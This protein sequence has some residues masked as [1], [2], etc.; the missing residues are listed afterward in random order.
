MAKR[1]VPVKYTSRDFETIR[2]DLVDYA[3]RYYPDTFK[4][5]SEASFGS[6]MLD[7]VAYVGDMLSFYVDYQANESFLDTATER[8]NIIR[9]AKEHGYKYQ[10]AATTVGE[11]TFYALIPANTSGLGPDSRYFPILK[12]NSTV[13]GGGAS[14]YILTEDVRFDNPG[15]Y[16]VASRTDPTTG[17]PTQYAVKAKGSVVSGIFGTEDIT[18][19][20]FEKFR[21][22][23]I[24]VS[25]VAEILQVLDADGNEYFEVEYL[26]HDVVYKSVP[27]RDANTRDN[28][29]SLLRPFSVPRRFTVERGNGATFLQFG[30]GSDSEISSPTVA[31]PST[32]IL[33]RHAKSYVTDSAFDPSDLMGTDKLGVGP[34]NTTLRVFY[35]R[36]SGIDSNAAVS[37]VNL[38]SNA[39][40]EFND[41]SLQ[42]TPTARDVIGSLEC[43]N[44]EPI[45]GSVSTPTLEDIRR[46][47]LNFFPTQNRAVTASDYEA[48][49]YAMPAELGALKRCR[50]V[51]D[52]DSLKRNLN[53][54]VLAENTTG[55]LATA[56]SALKQ[57]LKE[58]LN[59]YRMVNDTIDILDAKVV[60]IGIEFTVLSD[61]SVNKYDVLS[62]CTERLRA[63]LAREMYL[64]ERFYLTEVYKT[65]NR[66]PGVADALSAKIVNKSGGK[67]AQTGLSIDNF[68]STDGRYLSCP[69]NVAFEIKYPKTDIQGTVK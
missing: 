10:G 47:T 14:T 26:T 65:L 38:V 27:N 30:Q 36:N 66:V 16:V 39:I 60:N 57:N 5:F 44:E 58:W 25:H 51:R 13:S 3:K 52:Q 56:N 67:Y 11:V 63:D 32:V 22:V 37:A 18:I 31:E 48:L 21:K 53:M 55:R 33:K 42:N 1:K 68:M 23:P 64:G 62:A 29:P 46:E 24:N 28:T 35:R 61:V 54:Y 4:D 45:N 9:I 12:K 7:T 59:R 6:L 49:A 19:G 69:D 17:L 20:N 50:V 2:N 8:D 40:V 43:S 15:N 34:A 41:P